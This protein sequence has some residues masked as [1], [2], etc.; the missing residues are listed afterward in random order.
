MCEVLVKPQAGFWKHLDFG[1]FLHIV[2]THLLRVLAQHLLLL[3]YQFHLLLH[4]GQLLLQL[5]L[6]RVF[7]W[8]CRLRTHFRIGVHR[9]L[10]LRSVIYV[11]YTTFVA[12]VAGRLH[13][14]GALALLLAS[15]ALLGNSVIDS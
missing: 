15:I 4:H 8:V 3:L 5:L 7:I 14:I 12:V 6:A 13:R 11:V 1:L 9:L 2:M 10:A